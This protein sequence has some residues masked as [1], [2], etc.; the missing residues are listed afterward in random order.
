MKHAK[1]RR[2][3]QEPRLAHT[4]VPPGK[5]VSIV[6]SADTTGELPFRRWLLAA[7]MAL[8]VARPLVPS[9]GVSWVGDGQP[10]CMLWLLLATLTC[11]AAIKAD[12]LPRRW[13]W[14]DALL[15]AFVTI[16]VATAW[17]GSTL[18]NPR[19]A[20]N[21]LW[22]GMSM[23]VGFLLLRQLVRSPAESRMLVAVMIALALVVS[24]DGLYQ[25]LVSMPADR[26][27]FARDPEGML[28]QAGQWY[29]PGSPERTAFENRLASTEP[30]ATFALTNS[31]AGFLLPWLTIATGVALG[32]SMRRQRIWMAAVA[33]LPAF[34]LLLTKS[35]SGYVALLV[36]LVLLVGSR[37]REVL[38]AKITWITAACI[39][40]VVGA[41]FAGGLLDIQIAT[42]ARKSL[43]YRLQYWQSSLAMIRDQP[44]LGVGPGNFQ[45]Y[46][47][48]YKLP[49]ASEEIRDPH[50]W[51]LEIAATAG[52]PAALLL[53]AF[54]AAALVRLIA[55]QPAEEPNRRDNHE[56]LK[57]IAAGA[58]GG[59][60]VAVIVGALVG[61]PFGIERAVVAALTGAVA[62]WLLGDWVVAGM[63]PPR[64]LAIAVAAF[65]VH[66]LA[67]GGILF[68]GVNGSMW[69][70]LAVGLN[71]VE[72]QAAP[73]TRPTAMFALAVCAG[74]TIAQ[75]FTGYAP[76]LRSQGAM[77]E[78]Q[79]PQLADQQKE[80]ALRLAADADPRSA[81]PW[82]ELAALDLE[83]WLKQPGPRLLDQ[84]QQATERFVA[85]RP[86][87][88]SAYRQVGNWWSQ[89]FA[90]SAK[91]EHARLAVEN[92][93][94]ATT[95]YPAS[96][97]LR[98]ELA[99][100]L[101]AAGDANQAAEEAR[102]ALRLDEATPHQDKK[103]PT[104]L[105]DSMQAIAH[106]Q[107]GRVPE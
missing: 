72:P 3:E 32:S 80:A 11:M 23:G 38:R 9:A 8:F 6:I 63:L 16:F 25:V 91:P 45:D 101:T 61:L 85:L 71:L 92:L 74:L 43:G 29:P 47:T 49:E 10:F 86:H 46:Y 60:L 81:T 14:L 83:R 5:N 93:S 51:I 76:I 53:I 67:S 19:M 39:L 55:S 26:A 40:V 100:A 57:S 7:A 2:S 65:L 42:E 35:R 79:V 90:R 64:L 73:S 21:M 75:Y 30:L 107:A 106:S 66:L 27:E 98:A 82:Q 96:A 36:A 12:G 48:A 28:R 4:A 44:L 102:A 24:I 18:G 103:L 104:A 70:L 87:A 68:P 37:F 58:A 97:I 13:N 17:W 78:A 95:L 34:C 33:V 15:L 88:S 56:S 50:N 22:E 41:T 31:L 1:K 99:T 77:N 20:I 62:L 69:L 105:R 54:L 52:I 59:L 89:V 94:R 84:F